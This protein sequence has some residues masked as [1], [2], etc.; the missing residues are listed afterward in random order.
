[1]DKYLLDGH[2][3][4][5][6]LDRVEEWQAK[7]VV[8]PIYVE[9]S[10]LSVCNHKCIFCGIDSESQYHDVTSTAAS[11]GPYKLYNFTFGSRS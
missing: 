2:K 5:W 8:A 9:I 3:L 4:Y 1:M 11:V 10:P 6:H 7:K